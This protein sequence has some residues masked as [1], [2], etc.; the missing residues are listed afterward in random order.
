MTAQL[1]IVV[2]RPPGLRVSSPRT[3]LRIE[4]AGRLLADTELTVAQIAE[5]CG[6]SSPGSLSS[7]FLA[8]MGVRPSVYRKN[9]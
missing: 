6:F 8:H 7:A 1:G 5:R 4:Q 2:G 9:A 3:G